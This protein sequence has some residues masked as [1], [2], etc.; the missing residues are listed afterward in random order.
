M[1]NTLLAVGGAAIVLASQ[2]HASTKTY[3]HVAAY[4]LATLDQ[5]LR[6]TTGEDATVAKTGTDAKLA[7][8]GQG[9]HLLS[10]DEGNY[11]VE[12]PV[13]TGRSILSAMANANRPVWA[14]GPT[15]IHN[16]WFLDKVEPG[17][18]VLFASACAAPNKKHPNETVRCTF[19]FPDPDS[20][21]HEYMTLGDFTP[22]IQG[23]GSNTQ[24]VG[25]VLCG[26]GK[27]NPE[28]E[29]QLCATTS[30]AGTK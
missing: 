25:N 2:A 17:T 8:A 26:S 5:T 20:S 12:A 13:N 3:K 27:L 24:K 7:P 10:S 23:D 28:V 29:A 6:V 15:T 18:K 11:R 4:K 30:A 21:D 22:P 14:Q 9:I 16:K 19:W 1:K